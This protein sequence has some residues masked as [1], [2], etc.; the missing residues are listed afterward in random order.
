MTPNF[1]MAV[2]IILAHEGGYV[3]DPKDAGGET[4]YGISKRAY[5]NENIAHLTR[6]RAKEIYYRDY[7]QKIRGDKLPYGTALVLFDMAVNMGATKAIKIAQKCAKVKEDGLFGDKT[8]AAILDSGPIDMA[9]KLTH[10]RIMFYSSLQTF[11]RFGSGWVRRSIETMFSA[12]YATV[13]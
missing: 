12:I 7:W 6:E 8:L 13:K 5:P 3:N 4:K 11:S 10:E 9:Q 1:N 2:N